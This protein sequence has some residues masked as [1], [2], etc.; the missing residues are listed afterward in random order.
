MLK[1][2]IRKFLI[3]IKTHAKFQNAVISLLLVFQD[4]NSR[5][6]FIEKEDLAVLVSIVKENVGGLNLRKQ[7]QMFQ[8]VMS[9]L[10]LNTSTE[11]V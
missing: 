1:Q 3:A 2:H 11:N 8:A 4:M 5:E 6:I 9:L 10:L 7:H